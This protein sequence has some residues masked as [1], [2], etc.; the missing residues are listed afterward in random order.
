MNK[1]LL[2]RVHTDKKETVGQPL[3]SIFPVAI[4]DN[5]D[6]DKI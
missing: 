4:T 3:H 2:D 6:N 1:N 5:R